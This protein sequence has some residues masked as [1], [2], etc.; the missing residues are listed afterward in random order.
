MTQK[1]IYLNKTGGYTPEFLTRN[2][3]QYQ[4]FKM[5]SSNKRI[6]MAGKQIYY[7]HSTRH[8]KQYKRVQLNVYNFLE[9]PVGYK[10]LAYQFFM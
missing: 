9:R 10:A 5:T 8:S 4:N 1:F 6:S 7:P 3:M 2:N